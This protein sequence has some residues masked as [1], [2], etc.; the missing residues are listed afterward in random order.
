VLGDAKL[1]A[2][3]ARYFELCLALEPDEQTRLRVEKCRGYF[4]YLNR[5]LDVGRRVQARGG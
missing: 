2:R 4:E 3:L 5:M 1:D